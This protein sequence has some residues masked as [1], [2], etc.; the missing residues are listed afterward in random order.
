MRIAP[1]FSEEDHKTWSILFNNQTPLRA[2]QLV[3]EFLMGLELLGIDGKKIPDLELVNQ[4]LKKLTGWN[5]VYVEGFADPVAFFKMLSEKKFPVGSFI[6]DP[7]DLSYTPAPDVFHDLYGHIP[8]YT[9]QEYADFSEE[10]G[11]RV[12]KYK[13]E[14]KIV[15]EF[16]RLF[17]FAVEFGLLKTT[18][19]IRI[20]GAGIASSFSECEYALSNKPHVFPFNSEV[21]RN[22]NFRIDLLQEDLFLLDSV[23]DL[24]NG[25]DQFELPYRNK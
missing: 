16:Q 18:N 19:G 25:L 3:P 2:Q 8:F 13:N 15:E 1:N 23:E 21:I 11:K 22:K 4:K 7:K 12:L 6:R 10:F 17:W 14:P 24:Y 9:N 20:F 5:G